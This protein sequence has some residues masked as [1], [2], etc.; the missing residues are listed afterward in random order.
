[1]SSLK[2]SVVSFQKKDGKM[3]ELESFAK[4]KSQNV[5][6]VIETKDSNSP[7]A[8]A[9]IRFKSKETIYCSCEFLDLE[10]LYETERD[11]AESSKIT[12]EVKL[13]S[14]SNSHLDEYLD[15]C[16]KSLISRNSSLSSIESI[17]FMDNNE[18][19]SQTNQINTVRNENNV[20]VCSENEIFNDKLVREFSESGEFTEY[21]TRSGFLSSLSRRLWDLEETL[22]FTNLDSISG[23]KTFLLGKI[24][25]GNIGSKLNTSDHV[26]LGPK[27]DDGHVFFANSR[28]GYESQRSES[29][30]SEESVRYPSFCL[31]VNEKEI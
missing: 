18:Y 2:D 7:Q 20:K 21:H 4:Q 29:D 16:S 17:T 30:T 15:T 3:E 14:N 6:K 31:E 26:F 25:H 5:S 8:G 10:S 9:I 23:I 19:K 28:G 27:L 22:S 1:M 13:I 11:Q 24:G 12:K